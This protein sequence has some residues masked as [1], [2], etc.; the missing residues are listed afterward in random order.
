M[1][2]NIVTLH[3]KSFEISVERQDILSAIDS[4]A[5]R[6]NADYGHH[7]TPPLMIIT[8]SGAMMFATELALRLDFNVEIAFVKCSS[9]H[10]GISSSGKINFELECTISPLDRHVIVVEDIVETGN[11]YVALHQYLTQQQAT[12]IRIATLLRKPNLYKHSLPIDY[13]ALDIEDDFVVGFGLDYNQ[14]GRNLGSI[15]SLIK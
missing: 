11:T 3:D 13:V 9:Y 2:N 12:S 15:Y 8:L 14:L 6:L 5:Q 7:P 4:L 10:G 1:Q